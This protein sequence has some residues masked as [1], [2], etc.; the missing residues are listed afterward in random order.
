MRFLSFALLIMVLGEGQSRAANFSVGGSGGMEFPFWHTE[1][2][3]PGL[4]AEGFYRIDPYEVRFDY[5]YL[6]VH[7]YSVLLA[8]KFFFTQDDIRPFVEAALGPCFVNTPHKGLGY[9]ISP[10]ISLG[11]ELGINEHFSSSLTMRYSAYWYFGDTKSGTMEAN[12]GLSVVAGI[13][14]WF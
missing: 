2:M 10:E 9:G 8:K 1:R 13:S 3:D 11:A 4:R 7:Y 6:Q 5:S 12:H 14:L